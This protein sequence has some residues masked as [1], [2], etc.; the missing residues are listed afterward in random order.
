MNTLYMVVVV[1]S[2][3]FC[4]LYPLVTDLTAGPPRLLLLTS[5]RQAHFLA[6]R[7]RFIVCQLFGIGRTRRMPKGIEGRANRR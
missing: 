2:K 4:S 7:T 5:S 3:N 6:S 1:Y